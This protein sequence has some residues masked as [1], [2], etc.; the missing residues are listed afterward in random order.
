MGEG[1][2]DRS[3]R[4]TRPRPPPPGASRRSRPT[5]SSASSATTSA[6]R[7]GPTGSTSTT[8]SSRRSPSSRPTR[9]PP[10]RSAPASAGSASTSTRTRTRS[11]SASWSCGSATATTCASSATRTRRSTRSPA[12]PRT[13]SR[14]SRRATRARARSRCRATT[15]PRRRSWRSPTACWRRRVDGKRLV[16]TMPAGPAPSIGGFADG[17]AE[18]AAPRGR[19]IRAGCVAGTG[20]GAPARDR[21]PRP[22]QRPA[23]ADRGRADAGPASRSASA[24][25]GSSSGPRSATRSG[26]CGACRS[27]RRV[28]AARGASTARLS[29]ELGF[30]AR[31]RRGDGRRSPRPASGRPRSALCSRSPRGGRARARRRSRRRCS[32]SSTARAAAEAGGSAD[33]VNLLTFH[34]AKGLEWDAVFLPALEEGTLPIRQAE[35]RRGSPRSVGCCT[36]GSPGPGGTWAVLGGAARRPATARPAA[37]PAGSWR[38]SR[39]APTAPGRVT[40]LPGAPMNAGPRAAPATRTAR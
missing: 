18:L 36:S 13:T 26:S 16:A 23:P 2:P 22:D 4:P 24:A 33:G 5:C 12:R 10:R 9:T 32:P 14:A 29:A 37:G 8:C 1:P 6:R 39:V 19:R 27:R 21:G 20:I 7:R 40:V 35:S 15:G 25:S 3:P 34:R 31:G 17:E 38:P 28:A 30:E 11:S